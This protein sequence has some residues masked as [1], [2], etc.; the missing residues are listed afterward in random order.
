[1]TGLRASM[2]GTVSGVLILQASPLRAAGPPQS[3][4]RL[5]Q[6]PA[7]PLAEPS[8][9]SA[10]APSRVRLVPGEDVVL[11]DLQVVARRLDAARLSI[12]PS[13]GAT[14]TDFGR[15][16]IETIPQGDN[17]A[18][19]SVLLRAPG[20]V[21]DAFGNVFIRGDHRN[22]QY[23]INGVQLP[24]GLSGFA[25]TLQ[26]RFANQ[27]SLLTGALPAQ[28]GFRTAG[29]VDIQ[30]KTG[31]NSPGATVSPYGG[32]RGTVQ[33]SFEY[34]G[35]SGPVD[36]FFT[37]EYLRSNIGIE[38]PSSRLNARNDET[39][40]A[41][42]FAYVS[43][44][45]NDTT[46]L[47]L[48]TGTAY[49]DFRIPTR[50]GLT[51]ALGLTVNGTSDFDSNTLRQR[52]RQFQQFGILSLQKHTDS[53]DVQTSVFTRYDSL[54]YSP[55]PL[56]DLLF[57]GNAQS[58]RREITSTG[59]QTDAS[60]RVS[61]T[62]TLRAGFLAQVERT[63][64]RATNSVLPVD[65]FGAQTSDQPLSI[66]D[67]NARTGA[68]YGT[69][70]QD[71]WRVLPRVTLNYGLRGDIVDEYT[72]EAQISPRVNVVYKPF[73]GTTLHA[74]Y[75]RYFNPPPFELVGNA[76]IGR[77]LGTTAQPE[78][79]RSSP[80]KSERSHYFDAGIQQVVAPGLILGVDGFY[81]RATNLIDEGQFGSPVLLTAFNYARGDVTG[82]EFSGTY[83]RGPL[84]LFG[85]LTISRAI[86]RQIVSSE[87]NFSQADLD[88]ISQHWIKQDHDQRFTGSAGAAY[89][90]MQGQATPLRLSADLLVG[91][92]LRSS[93][94][95]VPN[96]R[97]LGGYY[98]VNLSAVQK[99]DPSVLGGRG[100]G[101]ELRVD[102]INLL[103]RKY[104]LRDGSGLGVGNPQ[105]G[106]RRA[107]LAGVAQRF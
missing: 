34:G 17:A 9:P 10:A 104:V 57:N 20:V 5:A 8:A 105:Y 62:H 74:G 68:F 75:A 66:G 36:Y 13:L 15:T 11:D 21:Q 97:A 46:R 99:L 50:N 92:G 94:S 37:G 14:R 76:T 31:V 91:S 32:S 73:D 52:Q 64:S 45:L 86:G 22:V 71:E 35:R 58:A 43:G 83:E 48:M 56:G 84:A 72:H 69:Y 61:D 38:N 1:M 42:G 59:L 102:V 85:N 2:L 70:L 25:S 93:T 88:Y 16:A 63:S 4:Q 77:V 96:G 100:R 101:T 19:N 82:V 24:E 12:Q 51:P 95:D 60:W 90:L 55:D 106:L 81:K 87:F 7:Q 30:T 44:I 6:Q 27:V 78:V 79:Q 80:V 28:Y 41:R 39:N 107:I 40:Q 53:A 18:L 23:R 33:P 47:T 98:T 26:A 67:K 3:T 49:G 29:V 103:D 65:E 54:R 89:T